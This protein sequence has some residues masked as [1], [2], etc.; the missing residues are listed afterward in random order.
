MTITQRF[1][2]TA[3]PLIEQSL[4]VMSIFHLLRVKSAD[5]LT[6]STYTVVYTFY[7]INQRQIGIHSVSIN[8]V[9]QTLSEE[10]KCALAIDLNVG[11]K[12]RAACM[13]I[14]MFIMLQIYINQ[15]PLITKID[16]ISLE[17]LKPIIQQVSINLG[18][19]VLIFC[20]IF[21]QVHRNLALKLEDL[22]TVKEIVLDTGTSLRI[23]LAN[24][25]KS[26][27]SGAITGP[28]L[29]Q[30]IDIY[31]KDKSD[32]KSELSDQHIFVCLVKHMTSLSIL[33]SIIIH[34][35][36]TRTNN[37]KKD[38]KAGKGESPVRDWRFKLSG[39]L[40]LAGVQNVKGTKGERV[41]ES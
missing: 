4:N 29:L 34:Q 7:W 14:N 22:G 13:S 27:D 24:G 9:L 36:S 18:H 40:N 31:K 1:S 41:V 2:K 17:D 30:S 19:F 10:Q 6:T 38:G 5:G 11:E 26:I 35:L 25:T 39:A 20:D 12:P 16:H 37:G 33:G 23:Q 28:I 8:G 32:Y 15:L 21:N 3:V